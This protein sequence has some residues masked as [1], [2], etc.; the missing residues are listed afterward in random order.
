MILIL[1]RMNI[2]FQESSILIKIL[3][4]SYR[5]RSLFYKSNLMEFFNYPFDIKSSWV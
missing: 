5:N 3:Q 1:D 2:Y 4:M